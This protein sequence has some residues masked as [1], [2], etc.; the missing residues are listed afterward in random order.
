MNDPQ[1]LLYTNQ[2]INTNI[3]NQNEIN[4]ESKN[5]D[6]FIEYESNLNTEETNNTLKYINNDDQET[7]QFNIQKSFYKPFPIE[8]HKNGYPMFDPLLKDLS[9]DT[10][11]RI[12]ETI[13][14]IDTENRNPI[15]YPYSSN[16]KINLPKTLNNIHQ[17]EIS[18]INIPNFLKSVKY[19]KNNFAWQYFNDYYLNTDISYNL[20]PFTLYKDGKYYSYFD[21][22]Y[23]SYKLLPEI[24]NIDLTYDPSQFLTYQVNI[25]EGNYT[26]DQLLYE[27]EKESIKIL[28]AVDNQN[29]LQSNDEN[30]YKIYEE[31]YYSFKSL[32]N[33]PTNWNFE[34]NKQSGNIFCVNRIE[35]VDLCSFQTFY[36]DDK[37][38]TS[39]YFKKYDMFYGYSSLGEDYILDTNYIYITVPLIQDVTDNWIDNSAQANNKEIYPNG[40]YFNPYKINPFPLVISADV[41]EQQKETTF[42]NFINQITMTTF[43]DIRVYTETPFNDE[44]VR[45]KEDE[46]YNLSYYKFIDIITLPELNNNLIRIGLRW[47]PISS[48][49]APFQNSFPKIN[50][51]YFKPVINVSIITSELLQ[52]YYS[53]NNILKNLTGYKNLTTK[54]GRALPCRLIYGKYNNKYQNYKTEYVNDSKQSI[55][56][57][58][59]FA[60]A[61][62][63][64]GEVKNI[65]NN[66]FSFIH[67]NLYGTTLTSDEPINQFIDSVTYFN[68]KKIDLELKI[69]D[70]NFYLKNN[71]YIFLKISFDGVDLTKIQQNQNE[72]ATSENQ[73]HVNQ[74]YSNSILTNYLGIGETVDCY[75]G[76]MKI[77]SKNYEGIFCKI[78][79]STIPGSIDVKDNNI[80]SKII[81]NAYDNL[82]SNIY[83]IK[84]QLL[85]FNLK[86]IETKENFNFDLK[87]I[88]SDSKLKETN[89]NTKTNKID[90]VGKNY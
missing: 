6:R 31:P 63:T 23:S 26:V 90:L 83:N 86:E 9:K 40:N 81:F 4:E 60:I 14:N 85:D 58:L 11:T 39:D 72:L 34:Y 20:I 22:P 78:L 57:Y 66:G 52:E 24:I 53:R 35:A 62:S 37:S 33:G 5:Y 73:N 38:L 48:K 13:I 15:F 68:N 67:S 80:S 43:W 69:V 32:R 21:I 41:S 55:M 77:K 3:I 84:I 8:N 82:L 64:N 71:N 27:I 76:L 7:D 61:N 45:Y 47:S 10:Y 19:M 87:F 29:V 36:A 28:H 18:N 30:T 79:T 51:E 50:F 16:V 42:Y 74:N 46:L 1:D 49:G 70:N 65:N 44:N 56:E 88:F 25:N 17:I 2:F 12:K 59:N 89:I 75:N 54:I